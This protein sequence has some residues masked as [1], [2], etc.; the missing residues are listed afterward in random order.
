MAG[1]LAQP[2]PQLPAPSSQPGPGVQPVVLP[3]LASGWM[4]VLYAQAARYQFS[5]YCGSPPFAVMPAV[6][7]AFHLSTSALS[8]AAMLDA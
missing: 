2:S 7:S 5:M 3:W 8:D 1:L 6:R 4:P